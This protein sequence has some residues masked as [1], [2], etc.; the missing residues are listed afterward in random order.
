MLGMGG[1]GGAAGRPH[2]GQNP[3]PGV[4]AIPHPLQYITASWKK[5]FW[6]YYATAA[7]LVPWF[8]EGR[9]EIC[10]GQFASISAS[11]L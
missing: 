7:L 5:L 4:I 6:V 10:I 2:C 3:C 11:L 9:P 1:T 8:A